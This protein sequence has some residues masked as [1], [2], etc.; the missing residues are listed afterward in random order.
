MLAIKEIP[1]T[2]GSLPEILI[3]FAATSTCACLSA[4]LNSGNDTPFFT[5][6]RTSGL[7]KYRRAA[8]K[9]CLTDCDISQHITT[10]LLLQFTLLASC[11]VA[12]LLLRGQSC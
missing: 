10:V 11:C 12:A 1:S 5:A 6:N 3:C 8:S 9:S 2:V 4:S 7:S